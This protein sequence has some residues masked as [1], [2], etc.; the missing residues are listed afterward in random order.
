MS[1]DDKKVLEESLTLHG[2]ETVARLR[3]REL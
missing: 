3:E 1:K 2:T